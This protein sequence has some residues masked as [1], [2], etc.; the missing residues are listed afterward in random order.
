M[1]LQV[2]FQE[3]SK[4]KRIYLLLIDCCLLHFKVAYKKHIKTPKIVIHNQCYFSVEY[5]KQFSITDRQNELF[6]KFCYLCK[7]LYKEIKKNIFLLSRKNKHRV[8][9]I[10]PMKVSKEYTYYIF[11]LE[12]SFEKEFSLR[13]PNTSIPIVLHIRITFNHNEEKNH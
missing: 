9:S 5:V 7:V 12:N 2:S 10:I 13:I 4:T 1:Y 11:L 6:C 8:I 3:S